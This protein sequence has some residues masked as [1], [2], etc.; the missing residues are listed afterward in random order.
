MSEKAWENW[1]LT[2]HV[3]LITFL[4]FD[5][6]FLTFST[7]DAK[8]SNFSCISWLWLPLK[9]WNWVHN[10]SD[11]KKLTLKTKWVEDE[12]QNWTS[13]KFSLF[14]NIFSFNQTYFQFCT[15]LISLIF[16]KTN[17]IV[18]FRNI[19]IFIYRWSIPFN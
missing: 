12:S 5:P 11:C 14:I 2:L 18:S 9:I 17:L 6:D 10:C 4:P 19:K 15:F 8:K 3:E 1:L 7:L 16:S 13:A